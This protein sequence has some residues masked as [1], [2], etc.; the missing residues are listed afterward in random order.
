MGGSIAR[1]ST[2]NSCPLNH[3]H[4]FG[5]FYAL[6]IRQRDGQRECFPWSHGQI[7]GETPA[8]TRKVPYSAVA[9]EWPQLVGDS[10]LH[11]EAK[12]GTNCN[13]HRGLAGR[14]IV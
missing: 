14:V 11:R 4:C 9:L 5:D 12:E 10:A 2:A 3:R 1:F 7:T 13:G 6:F 8:G